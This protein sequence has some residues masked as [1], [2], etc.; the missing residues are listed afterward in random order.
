MRSRVDQHLR[1]EA[2]VGES[3]DAYFREI[4]R[5]ELLSAHEEV[6]LAQKL[7]AGKAAT[8]QL[9][10]AASTLG[11][12]D[13]LQLEQLAEVGRQAQR[14][15]IECNLR[16][17][18]SVARHFLG[19]GLTLLDLVQEGNMGLQTGVGKYDWQRGFRLST[20]VHWWIRQSIRHALDQHSRTI[21]LPSHVIALLTEANRAESALVVELGRQPTEDELAHRL[22]VDPLQ[23][24]AARRVAHSPLQLDTPARLGE[25]D[26]RTL[27]ESLADEAAENAGPRAAESAD[28]S[29]RLQRIL[30]ELA[31][32]D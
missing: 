20:Y 18:V 4:R 25:D 17:V 28:L 9:R 21:R 13:H 26:Q 24:R 32:R 14:R 3:P 2:E 29:E 23:L 15:L 22:D 11:Q 27:G 30:T 5:H 10:A 6:A 12:L 16:L 1:G 19:R 8:V 31:P 7:E